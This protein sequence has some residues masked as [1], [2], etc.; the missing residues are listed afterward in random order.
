MGSSTEKTA[1][2]G[3]LR[4]TR[5]LPPCASTSRLT[6]ESPGPCR[7]TRASTMSRPGRTVENA[8]ALL[9]GMPMPRVDDAHLDHAAR[10]RE[11]A[12]PLGRRGAAPPI[13][14]AR[15]ARCRRRA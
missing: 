14:R 4:L 11:H 10:R 15:D 2:V 12:R 5:T 3:S 1:P 6:I 9:F 7:R 8:L 13:V